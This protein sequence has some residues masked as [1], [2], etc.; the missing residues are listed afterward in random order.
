MVFPAPARMMRADVRTAG[1]SPGHLGVAAA[2]AA[3]VLAAGRR[4]AP[5]GSASLTGGAEL[6][7]VAR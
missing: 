4:E 5:T 6:G 7:A 2:A 1:E 3:V